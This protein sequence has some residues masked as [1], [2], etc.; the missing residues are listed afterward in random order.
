MQVLNGR[1]TEFESNISRLLSNIL[2]NRTGAR[3]ETTMCV[4]ENSGA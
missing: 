3:Y 4:A 1:K 2:W